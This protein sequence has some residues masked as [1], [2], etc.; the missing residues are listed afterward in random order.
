MERIATAIAAAVDPGLAERRRKAAEKHLSRVTMFREPSGAAALSGRDL[1]AD[2][3][4][5]AFAHVNART[6]V[7]KESG[8]FAK[9][10][11]DRL[12]ATAYLDILNEIAAEDRIAYGRLSPPR[13][14]PD[15]HATMYPDAPNAGADLDGDGVHHD[16][17]DSADDDGQPRRVRLPLRR[18][19]R[20]VRAARRQPIFPTTLPFSRRVSDRRGRTGRPP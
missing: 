3:T 15:P 11:M 9:E 8:A 12:R 14:Q 5:A 16:T 10:G 17:P 18:V 4:L 1:P 2:E 7:Y 13:Q 6:Q 20:P 19:R